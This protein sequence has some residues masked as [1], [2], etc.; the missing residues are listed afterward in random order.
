M[1]TSPPGL[2]AQGTAKPKRK[3]GFR[4][5]LLK[6]G[7]RERGRVKLQGLALHAEELH[8]IFPVRH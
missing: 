3:D 5:A 6:A 4:L 1:I 8:D 2:E 7:R